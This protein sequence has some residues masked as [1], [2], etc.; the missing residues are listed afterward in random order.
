MVLVIDLGGRSGCLESKR[1]SSVVRD[2]V[3]AADLHTDDEGDEQ[4][5]H[6]LLDAGILAGMLKSS[7]FDQKQIGA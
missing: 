6:A 3:S 1:P 4:S 5:H 2:P 7:A